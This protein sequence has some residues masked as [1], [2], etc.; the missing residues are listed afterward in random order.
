MVPLQAL[1]HRDLHWRIYQLSADYA[2]ARYEDH[3]P[4]SGWCEKKIRLD[5]IHLEKSGIS[6]VRPCLTDHWICKHETAYQS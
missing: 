1:E 3:R 2:N 5:Y 6:S 4:G